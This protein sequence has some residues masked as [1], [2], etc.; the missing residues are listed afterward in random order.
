MAESGRSGANEGIRVLDDFVCKA[1]PSSGVPRTTTP[2]T[3]VN[4]DMNV[5]SEVPL[6]TSHTTLSPQRLAELRA[7]SNADLLA[8][9]RLHA[10]KLSAEELRVIHDI[11]IN[12]LVRDG[13]RGADDVSREAMLATLKRIAS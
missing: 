6:G 13:A 5:L 3:G 7:L 9:V 8:L 2:G 12:R 11:G 10:S 4:A 1:I